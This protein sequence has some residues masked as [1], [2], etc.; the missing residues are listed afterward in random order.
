MTSKEFLIQFKMQYDSN[1]IELIHEFFLTFSR[2]EYAL[3]SAGFYNGSEQRIEPSWDKF[4]G[5]IRYIFD[6]KANEE[7]LTAVD[8]LVSHPPKKQVLDAGIMAFKSRTNLERQNIVFRLKINICDIRNN[9][10]HGGKFDGDLE[11][12]ISR[13]Y[14]LLN[15]ALI[16]LN[17]W[18][19]LNEEVNR[20]FSLPI[21]N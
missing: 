12:E 16:V 20:Y 7:L 4:A 2:F 14:I 15:S 11:P 5:S 19:L 3:K 17:N 9:L 1:G 13:N 8:Y 10:F 21:P 18:L 6:P